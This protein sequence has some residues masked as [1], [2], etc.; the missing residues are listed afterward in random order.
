M[1]EK[2]SLRGVV[3]LLLATSLMVFASSL[4]G[5]LRLADCLILSHC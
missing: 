5:S 1:N 3:R 2:T 4:P